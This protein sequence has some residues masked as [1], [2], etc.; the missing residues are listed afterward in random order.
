M[1]F[2]SCIFLIIFL[3]YFY[4]ISLR[5]TGLDSLKLAHKGLILENNGSEFNILE[6]IRL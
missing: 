5:A 3:L 2:Y 4:F 6:F 1:E